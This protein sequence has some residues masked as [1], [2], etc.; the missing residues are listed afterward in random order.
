MEVRSLTNPASENI[1][2]RFVDY[3]FFVPLDSRGAI[4]QIEGTAAVR[5]MSAEEVEHLVAEGYDPGII[6]DDGT[7]TV[8]SFMA[9]GVEMWN[10]DED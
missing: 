2:V 3:G 10:R 5:T 7:A 1:N 4:V 8:V 6:E 9:T